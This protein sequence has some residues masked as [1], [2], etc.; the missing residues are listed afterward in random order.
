MI[1]KWLAAKGYGFL[2]GIE[3]WACYPFG[4]LRSY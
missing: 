1:K 4:L 3:K 2:V